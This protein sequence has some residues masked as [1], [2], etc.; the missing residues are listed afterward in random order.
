M[1]KLEELGELK[2]VEYISKLVRDHL[3]ERK[4][5]VFGVGDDAQAVLVDGLWV[6]LKIDGTT[7]GSSMYP[8]LT[9]SEFGYRVALSAITDLVAK[10]SKPL[11]LASSITISGSSQL[12]IV[13]N[14][15]AGMRE[16]AES[17]GSLYVGGDINRLS[18]SDVV[19]DVASIG[20]S[21]R[22]KPSTPFRA[23]LT[24]YSVKC[25]GLSSIPAALYYLKKD[26][27]PWKDVLKA[28]AKP[29]P[30]L[31]FLTYSDLVEAST[32]ISDG[33]SSVRRVLEKSGS[34][35]VLS[36]EAI[37]SEVIEFSR[38]ERVELN[39]LLSLMGEEYTVIS[40]AGD[41][42][43]PATRVGRTVKGVGRIYLESHELKGGWDNFLGYTN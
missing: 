34:D 3:K 35:L 27:S 2:V 1:E 31:K 11:L 15:V 10:N 20:V 26:F 12:E 40:V 9:F 7:A 5:E 32:D 37:C 42:D 18:H 14:I 21:H 38:E 8:W 28:V 43:L 25:L 29:E 39:R 30:P 24:V 33:L 17:T 41:L 4:P 36:Y 13:L 6:F 19:V 16:L 22:P 23:D